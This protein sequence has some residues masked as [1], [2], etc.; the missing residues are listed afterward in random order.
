M[1]I[2]SLFLTSFNISPVSLKDSRLSL[3]A[4]SVAGLFG[5]AETVSAMATVHVYEGRKYLGW[6]NSPGAYGVSQRL[7]QLAA[8]RFSNGLYPGPAADPT[9]LVGVEA[10][11]GPKF[12]SF[13]SGTVLPHSGHLGALVMNECK[14]MR[15][16]S[17]PGRE[18]KGAELFVAVLDLARVPKYEMNP[19]LPKTCSSLLAS[20]PIV[21][22]IATCA[23]SGLYGDW[24]SCGT[25]FLGM[26]TGGIAA[27]ALGSGRLTFTHPE[28]APSCP[29]GDGILEGDSGVAVL[30][31]Q[32]GAVNA[33]TR[34]RFSLQFRNEREFKNIRIAAALLTLQFIAQLLLVPQ[35]SLF[36]QLMFVTS[37]A[38]SWGYN[39]WLSSL[40]KEKIQREILIKHILDNPERR[41]F[42]VTTRTALAVL[43]CLILSPEDPERVLQDLVPND[44]KV[45]HRFRRGIAERMTT[46]KSA[47]TLSKSDLDDLSDEDR[48]L[49]ETLFQ[50]AEGARKGYAEYFPK[51]G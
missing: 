14:E 23:L 22:S 16:E 37:L 43:V 39:S 2:L 36:G 9:T 47:F 50:D 30:L 38:V 51:R 34:G 24:Y 31:G 21:T 35:G 27:W 18:R 7:S 42:N 29:L 28:P 33:I 46:G 41:K 26:T 11:K 19:R 49:L 4:F 1:H 5:G 15:G 32:E 40:D 10:L 45:W 8:S 3:D 44:T 13:T 17:V 25:I 48:R 6:H 20:I 12:K